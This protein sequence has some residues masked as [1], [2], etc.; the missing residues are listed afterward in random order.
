MRDLI[1]YG[2]VR[3]GCRLCVLRGLG[4]MKHLGDHP[5][6]GGHLAYPLLGPTP[7]PKSCRS[8]DANFALAPWTQRAGV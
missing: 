6:I 5:T 2:M 4:H 8:E 1:P 7:F 3:A